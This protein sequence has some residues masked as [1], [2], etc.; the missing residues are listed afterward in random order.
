[1]GIY[2]QSVLILVQLPNLVFLVLTGLSI[3]RASGQTKREA[4]REHF[5]S[6]VKIF[7]LLGFTWTT[8]V[9]STFL[10]VEH[11]WEETFY[12]RLFLDLVNLFLGVLLFYF[13]VC[14][15]QVLLMTKAKIIRRSL[16]NNYDP[17]GLK[18]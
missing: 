6:F 1:M 5:F 3:K 8:E 14:N 17:D 2:Q 13:L 7:F 4:A 12:V 15:K 11:G 16:S 9:I 18:M 10:A